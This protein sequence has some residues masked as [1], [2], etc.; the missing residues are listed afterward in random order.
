M[1]SETDNQ[2]HRGMTLIEVLIVLAVLGILLAIAIPNLRT[3]AVRLAGNSVQSFLQQARF[4]AIRLNGAVGVTIESG[5]LIS[6][7][8]SCSGELLNRL[9]LSDYPGVTLLGG[10]LLWNETGQVRNCSGGVLSTGGMTYT[11][12]DASRSVSVQVG[13]A[14]AVSLR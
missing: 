2:L 11:V 13:N 14:G 1:R 7:Q 9:E 3:P 8:G 12:S 5:N 6:R 10:S 4:D